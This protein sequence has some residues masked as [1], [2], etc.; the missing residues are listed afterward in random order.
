LNV[1]ELQSLCTAHSLLFNRKL[2]GNS[3]SFQECSLLVNDCK[4]LQALLDLVVILF[5]HN[6]FNQA[7]NV[8]IAFKLGMSNLS[9]QVAF[10]KLL[11]THWVLDSLCVLGFA[12]LLFSEVRFVNLKI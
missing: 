7:N 2:I 8:S 10:S 6:S 4:K 9:L 11:K 5:F 3:I 12:G 1:I